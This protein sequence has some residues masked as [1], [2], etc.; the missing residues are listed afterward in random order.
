MSSK[1]IYRLVYESPRKPVGAAIVR[2]ALHC[3]PTPLA[4]VG[5]WVGRVPIFRA[6]CDACC[7]GEARGA[8]RSSIRRFSHHFGPQFMWIGAA[9]ADVLAVAVAPA[10]PSRTRR[11]AAAACTACVSPDLAPEPVLGNYFYGAVRG[12]VLSY[13]IGPGMVGKWIL[14]ILVTGH[15]LAGLLHWLVLRD[16]VVHGMLGKGRHADTIRSSDRSVD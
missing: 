6:E 10:A 2:R 8:I 15:M 13:R 11:R 12:H 1:R 7:N 14:G 5:G 4:L 3:K 9:G 16:G